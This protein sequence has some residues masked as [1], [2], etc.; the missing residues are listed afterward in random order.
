LCSSNRQPVR[1]TPILR[2]ERHD[3]INRIIVE[4]G[5]NSSV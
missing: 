5:S 1:A 2:P 3:S 4:I